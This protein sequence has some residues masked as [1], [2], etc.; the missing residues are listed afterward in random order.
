MKTMRVDIILWILTSYIKIS[1]GHISK[2]QSEPVDVN[3]I[4]DSV[5]STSASSTDDYALLQNGSEPKRYDNT[6]QP[7]SARLIMTRLLKQYRLTRD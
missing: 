3:V 4:Y 6:T 1:I 5:M 2:V 7:L